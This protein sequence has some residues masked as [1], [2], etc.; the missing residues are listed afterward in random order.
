MRLLASTM[1]A[2][3]FLV[4]ACSSGTATPPATATPSP[5]PSATP[6]PATPAPPPTATPTAAPTT[7]PTPTVPTATPFP[8]GV[9]GAVDFVKAYEDA[10]I[11][12]DFAAAWS[13]LG[14]NA[15]AW[16]DYASFVTERTM[17]LKTAGAKYTTVANP[18]GSLSL[19]DWLNGT[20]FAASIDKSHAVLVQ[21]T[22]T[23]L[24]KNDAGWEMW[25]V[26]P[27]PTGWELYEVR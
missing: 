22:W 26:N 25:V 5:A 14:P 24:A 10:L 4:A 3:A 23:A 9:P 6:S 11:A 18:S 17:Y 15:G 27:T 1:L 16:T 19:A 2:A 12:G 21:V 20:S 8:T 7:T 13:M